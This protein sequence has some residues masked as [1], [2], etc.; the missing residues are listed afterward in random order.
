[1]SDIIIN[2]IEAVFPNDEIKDEFMDAIESEDSVFSFQ[3]VGI[4]DKLESVSFKPTD[5][6]FL[7]LFLTDEED[8]KGELMVLSENFSSIT[9]NYLL[10]SPGSKESIISMIIEAGEVLSTQT[11][12]GS[13]A[14]LIGEMARGGFAG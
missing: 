12:I 10:V 11:I 8:V 9:F 7:F 4:D 3:C 13:A 5:D 2:L 6:G 1:M 14:K